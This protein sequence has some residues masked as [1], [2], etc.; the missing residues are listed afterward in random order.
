MITPEK[1][2]QNLYTPQKLLEAS[3]ENNRWNVSDGKYSH[4]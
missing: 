3:K 1:Y 2:P 4:L